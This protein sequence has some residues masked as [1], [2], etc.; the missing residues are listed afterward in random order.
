V[1]RLVFWCRPEA[2][3]TVRFGGWTEAGMLS[4]PLFEA[5][6]PDVPAVSCRLPE[7]AG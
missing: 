3:T 6:R 5:F 4:F 2:S 7:S 1:E